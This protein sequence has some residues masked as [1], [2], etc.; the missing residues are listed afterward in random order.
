MIRVETAICDLCGFRHSRVRRRIPDLRYGLSEQEFTVVSC[1]RCGHWFLNPRPAAREIPGLYPA[2]YYRLRDRSFAEQQRRYLRQANYIRRVGPGRL[3]DIG[4]AGGA[5]L[6]VMK[7]LGWDCC[8]MDFVAPKAVSLP[9]DIDFKFGSLEE[10]GY[11]AE[12]FD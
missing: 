7:G 12:S 9:P 3:L 1:S 4:C 6:E 11:S 5:F 8:G 2:S 10:I